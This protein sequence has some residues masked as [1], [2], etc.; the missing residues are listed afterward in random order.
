MLVD[1]GAA[2]IFIGLL[3][4]V[5]LV[6]Y[7]VYALFAHGFLI[8]GLIVVAVLLCGLGVAL[9]GA[10]EEIANIKGRYSKKPSQEE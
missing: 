4:M 8:V 10:G 7:A 1:I 2:L 9:V 5:G 6:G 3:L